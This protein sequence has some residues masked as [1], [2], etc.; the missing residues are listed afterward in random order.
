MR[1]P[2]SNVNLSGAAKWNEGELVRL[3]SHGQRY[4]LEALESEGIGLIMGSGSQGR[5]GKPGLSV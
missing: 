3:Q 5:R 4:M 1:N 2:R